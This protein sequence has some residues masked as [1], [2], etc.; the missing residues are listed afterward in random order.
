MSSFFSEELVVGHV[1]THHWCITSN[2]FLLGSFKSQEQG[3]MQ[4]SSDNGK[5]NGG[6]VKNEGKMTLSQLKSPRPTGT[7]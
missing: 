1:S 5:D 4:I 6:Y 3:P 7:E 2:S